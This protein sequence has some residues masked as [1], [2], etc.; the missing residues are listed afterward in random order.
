MKK[1]YTIIIDWDEE[2]SPEEIKL[3]VDAKENAS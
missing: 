1:G 3:G 2:D